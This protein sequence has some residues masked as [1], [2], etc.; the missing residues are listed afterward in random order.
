MKRLKRR[1]W[2]S[3]YYSDCNGRTTH[4]A[5]FKFQIKILQ[6]KFDP[7]GLR[8]MH[9]LSLKSQFQFRFSSKHCKVKLFFAK[10][11]LQQCKTCVVGVNS[12]F[13]AW[14]PVGE[15]PARFNCVRGC[16]FVCV[17][18]QLIWRKEEAVLLLSNIWNDPIFL[19]GS[20]VASRNT[21]VNVLVSIDNGGLLV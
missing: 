5:A 12:S 6:Y 10:C 20:Q 14:N 15:W 7:G 19:A 13:L 16:V 1:M 2:N 18:G 8:P 21:E 17:C 11:T 9:W 4:W 3:L